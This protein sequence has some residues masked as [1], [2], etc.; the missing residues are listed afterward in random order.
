MK[1]IWDIFV[2]GIVAMFIFTGVFTIGEYKFQKA[3]LDERSNEIFLEYSQAYLPLNSSYANVSKTINDRGRNELEQEGDVNGLD[4]FIK[5]YGEAK[6]R[7]NTFR[8]TT[9]MITFI[10]DII[11]LSIPFVDPA[12]LEFYR[13]MLMF[14]IF[15]MI[16]IAI[17]M[18]LF[19]RKV[20]N[21]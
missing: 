11:V 12:D 16:G 9:S 8:Q 20:S 18:A 2:I 21:E 7:V 19:N 17:F 1:T 3:E 5:E 10:P 4:A 14:I 13:L 6:D 15:V